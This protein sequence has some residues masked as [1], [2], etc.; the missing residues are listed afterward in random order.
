MAT[1]IQWVLDTRK[2]WP[3]ASKTAELEH[4]AARAMD[5]LLP[6]EREAV[7]RYFH[8]RDAKLALG[9]ALLKRLVIAQHVPGLPWAAATAVR[10]EHTKPVFRGPDGAQPVLFNVSHQAGLVVLLAARAGAAG[11]QLGVDVVCPGERRARDLETVLDGRDGWA[12]YVDMHDSVL[13]PVEARRLRE[14]EPRD[15]GGTEEAE[16]DR[17]LAYFYALWCLRE[18]YV[19]MTGEALLASW[20]GELEM[21][22][23]APPGDGETELE[24]LFGPAGGKRVAD[25]D[26][27]IEWFLGR[28]YMIST[29]VRNPDPAAPL[30]LGRFELLD[31]EK[32]LRQAE[33]L[34]ALR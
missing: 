4:V 34:K 8:V 33:E 23:F 6:G 9:S 25:V 27:R 16:A 26:L 1:A 2:L 3:E 7:L 20:L 18:A 15:V 17:R 10:D 24:V 12:K 28:Q 29:A 31:L 32:V 5:L 22:G 21:R 30:R 19:K 13:S 11:T 14:M